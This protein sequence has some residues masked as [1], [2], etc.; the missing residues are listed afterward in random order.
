VSNT[1]SHA[2]YA[3]TEARPPRLSLRGAGGGVAGRGAGADPPPAAAPVPTATSAFDEADR[4]LRQ[5]RE[6]E[7]LTL[8][9][10]VLELD[11]GDTTRHRKDAS[12][13]AAMAVQRCVAAPTDEL[14]PSP[15]DELP[16]CEPAHRVRTYE[17]R[18]LT[19]EARRVLAAGEICLRLAPESPDAVAVMY[20]RA[21][22][23]Y[24]CNRWA[25]AMPLFEEIVEKYRSHELAGDA[26]NLAMDCAYGARKYDRLAEYATGYCSWPELTRHSD[27][28]R[29]CEVL[30]AK[31]F[32]E[33]IY[34]W[35]MEGR[36]E[37]AGDAYLKLATDHPG[38]PH[39]DELYYQAAILYE[40]ARQLGLAI[41]TRERLMA[42]RPGSKLS[43]KSIYLNGRT[44]E[45]MADFENAAQRYEEF[46]T[47]YPTERSRPGEK[48]KIDATAALEK[49]AAMRLALGQWDRAIDDVKLF[50]RLYGARQEYQARAAQLFFNLHRVYE[51]RGEP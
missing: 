10:R 29:Q 44:Y 40:R 41:A 25:E 21:F 35:E 15:P 47:R 42:L 6:C 36:Y 49:A 8:Y 2:I 33:R 51:A 1:R 22:L 17:P 9:L 4:L 23:F 46:A 14:G 18:T 31:Q 26:A 32:N 43:E 16:A 7:A 28:A 30:R 5:E 13:R 48:P 38:D 50:I 34:R 19:D 12:C 45:D 27:F 24:D 20:R 39:V 3:P 11:P 37:L